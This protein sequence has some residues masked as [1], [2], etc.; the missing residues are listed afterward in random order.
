MLSLLK[1]SQLQNDIYNFMVLFFS[2]V[3]VPEWAVCLWLFGLL[4][5]PIFGGI[6]IHYLLR[7]KYQ[8]STLVLSFI[9]LLLIFL[10]CH[11]INFSLPQSDYFFYLSTPFG[12]VA[13]ITLLFMGLPVIP[14]LIGIVLNF[15]AVFG[16]VGLIERF[17]KKR[18][19]R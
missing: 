18:L 19:D 4:T 15:L 10:C 7:K 1:N 9:A 6:G 16:I 12:F 11:L 13:T 3:F 5:C 8:Q 2:G 17:V 14:F